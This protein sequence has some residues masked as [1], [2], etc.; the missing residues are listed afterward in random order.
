[1]IRDLVYVW[2]FI[3]FQSLLLATLYHTI[4][5]EQVEIFKKGLLVAD[6]AVGASFLYR[7]VVGEKGL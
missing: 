7:K 4:F 5:L 6:L 2:L 1:M 3:F